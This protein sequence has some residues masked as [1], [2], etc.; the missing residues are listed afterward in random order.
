MPVISEITNLPKDV[1][2]V[3]EI[4]ESESCQT[5]SMVARFWSEPRKGIRMP[6]IPATASSG[7]LRLKIE[8]SN[9]MIATD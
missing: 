6:F 9:V 7:V 8:A 3:T 4:G 2:Y 1:P 5:P